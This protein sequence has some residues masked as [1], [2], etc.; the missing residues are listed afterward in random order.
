MMNF[1]YNRKTKIENM[2]SNKFE[3]LSVKEDKLE[4][5][6]KKKK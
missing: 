5:K 2:V 1:D 4:E 6:S 3:D